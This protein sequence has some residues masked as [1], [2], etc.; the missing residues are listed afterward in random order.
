MQWSSDNCSTLQ[1]AENLERNSVYREA[2]DQ[3]LHT[4]CKV[5]TQSV[6][7]KQRAKRNHLLE[8]QS[9]SKKDTLSRRAKMQKRERNREQR[10]PRKLLKCWASN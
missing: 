3:Y 1:V 4:F 5:C 9:T 2:R 8:K 10:R 7:E 6:F